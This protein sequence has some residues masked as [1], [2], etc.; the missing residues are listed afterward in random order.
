MGQTKAYAEIR[1]TDI[2]VQEHSDET[3]QV[4]RHTAPEQGTDYTE[5][6]V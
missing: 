2:G 3:E 5:L 6:K 1:K 4:Q